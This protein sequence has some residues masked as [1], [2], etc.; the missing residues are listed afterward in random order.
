[1]ND[2]LSTEFLGNPVSS[3]LLV[4][5]G[6]LVGF[7]LLK[8]TK[9][10]VLRRLRKFSLK[11]KTTIDDFLLKI[12]E[13]ALVPVLY[14]VI[15]YAGL[16]YL[17]LS[18][19]ATDIAKVAMLFICTFFALR[20]I[21]AVI[22]Y[23]ILNV[24]KQQDDGEAKQ[25]QAKGLLVIVKVIVWLFGIV[26]LLDNFGYNITTI[27]AGLGIGGIAIALA[28]Q[29]VLGDLFSY[30]SIL[31]DRPFE[32]GDF[33]IVDDKLG[34]VEYIG[35]KTT[36]L[37]SIEG[38]QLV[39]SNKDLTDSRIHNFKRMERRRVVFSIGVTYGTSPQVLEAIPN[40]VKAIIEKDENLVFDRGHFTTFGDFSLNF[41]FVYFILTSDFNAHRDAQ[42][43]IFYEIYREFEAKGIEFAF[44][45]QT[46]FV[47][48]EGDPEKA[49]LN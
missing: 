46:L 24:L 38:D 6:I 40:M 19:K 18:E 1:M 11:T 21:N 48:Q 4:I 5:G 42:Q 30:F 32:I 37:K 29:T 25:K 2:F 36:R 41:E 20:F 35:I 49:K 3:W 47:N 34:V 27:V 28:A 16:Q 39:C 9:V 13:K 45:T 31:F 26:F 17:E 15:I 8:L 10:L 23:A 33:I 14:F 44:P 43:R 22:E 12:I 7:A